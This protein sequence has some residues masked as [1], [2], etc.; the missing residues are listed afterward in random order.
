MFRKTSECEMP[1]ADKDERIP[2]GIIGGTGLVGRALSV[3][4]LSHPVF[5]LG[6]VVGS[7]A[8]VGKKFRTVWE[9]KEAALANHYGGNLW[10]PQ[11]F[12]DELNDVVVQSQEELEESKCR[13][14]VSAIAPRFGKIEDDLQAKG[15]KVFSISPHA[16]THPENP[17]VV[18]EAN[19]EAM[20][21]S[22]WHNMDLGCK[23]LPLIKSPNCVTCGISVVLKAVDEAF[24]LEGVAVT[25]FQALSG[26][27]DAKYDP[28]LVVGNVYPLTGTE[29]RTDEYQRSELM[30][31]FPGITRCSVSAHRVPVQTGHFVDV[32][33]Q[34]RKKIASATAVKDVMRQFNPLN[35]LN[36]PS[37]PKM[38]IV[39]VDEPGRPRPLN[40]A[41]YENGMAVAVGNIRTDDGFFDLTLSIVLN[42]VAR[43]AWGAALINAEFYHLHVRPIIESKHDKHSQHRRLESISSDTCWT[44]ETSLSNA[45]VSTD[46]DSLDSDKESMDEATRCVL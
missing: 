18:P 17:L 23:T 26:R 1:L 21:Q 37:Q 22:L 4:L 15:F 35:G 46:L 9:E 29:E 44:R 33:V 27:G 14:V 28:A 42:N 32:K 19:G 7:G 12:P 8:T 24:G 2:M 20:M 40:D 25:T 45:S 6:P 38:P 3:Q 34:T 16:R 36:L 11:H 39:V 31:I 41:D 43:G 5:C 30:R 13:Y 10:I